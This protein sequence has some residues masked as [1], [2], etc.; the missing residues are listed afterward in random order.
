VCL[1]DLVV[2]CF[3]TGDVRGVDQGLA[4][5]GAPLPTDTGPIAFA[6]IGSRLWVANG[7]ANTVSELHLGP[8]AP[9]STRGATALHLF[10][11]LG[12]GFNDLEDLA[13]DGGLLYVTNAAVNTLVVV[14][15]ALGVVDEVPVG[16]GFDFPQGLAVTGGK[17]FVALNGGNALAVVDV[18]GEVGCQPPDPAAPACDASCVPPRTCVADRCQRALCGRLLGRIDLAALA[19]PGGSALPARLLAD[20]SSAR[21]PR[22]FA[23]LNN[24]VTSDFSYRPAGNGRLAVV[25]LATGALDASTPVLDLGADCQN[26]ADLALLG[27]TLWVTCGYY[28]YFGTKAI[29]GAAFVPVDLSGAT[30]AVGPAVGVD[31]AAP[32]SLAFCGGQGFAGDRASG[33]L[34]RLDPTTHDVVVATLCPPGAGG[35]AQVAGWHAERAARF[36]AAAPPSAAGVLARR[37]GAAPFWRSRW[38]SSPRRRGPSPR[39]SRATPRPGSGRRP[40]PSPGASSRWRRASP[41]RSRPWGSPTGSSAS[42]ATTMRPR[43]R[44]SGA[45]AA[46][47]TPRPRPSWACG[48]TSSS[49]SPTAAPFPRCDASPTSASRCG[50]CRW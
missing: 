33:K 14:D 45:S 30:P 6:G 21:P 39:R 3:N 19:S 36:G 46:S 22:L 37:E 29:T 10:T 48:P 2:A 38:R 17:A 12:A 44:A 40:R 24:L 15:P 35:L 27:E 23:V 11:N 5:V 50:R 13:A 26:P 31:G 9:W 49:G 32:G 25:D 1:P 34:L 7:L 43:S 41:T 16:S 28:D 18:S 42:P 20:A 47:S 4:Q 8:P